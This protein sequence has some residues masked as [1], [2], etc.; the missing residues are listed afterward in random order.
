MP[1]SLGYVC[2]HP[3]ETDCRRGQVNEAISIRN[4]KRFAAEQDD[5]SWKKR[6]FQKPDTGKKV[7]VI[8]AGPAGP[9]CCLLP[10]QA[11]PRRD[12]L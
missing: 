9:D 12:G 3:C 7:A 1:L 5:G 10:A 11:G 6:G 4:L 8:G 2:S